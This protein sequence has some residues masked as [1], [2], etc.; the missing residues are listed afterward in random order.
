M[1]IKFIVRFFL[2]QLMIGKKEKIIFLKLYFL[3]KPIALSVQASSLNLNLSVDA[4]YMISLS[5]DA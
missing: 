1:N 2:T 5:V 4:Q 3:N